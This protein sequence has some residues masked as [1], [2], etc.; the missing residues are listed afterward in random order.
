MELLPRRIDAQLLRD[1]D[2]THFDYFTMAVLT[3]SASH[4]L[5]MSELAGLTNATRPRLSHVIS[6]LEKRGYVT[7]SK[8]S[9]DGRGTEVRLTHEGRRKA[10]SATPAHVA[11][12]R[13]LVLDALTPEQHEQLRQIA[14][15]VLG[16]LDPD[17]QVAGLQD[18]V[19]DAR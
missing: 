9:A 6:R 14:Y 13:E 18:G 16:R 10:I 8:T 7:R 1:D 15:R 12:V 17:G 19:F 5:R 3:R 2:L 11:A 4:A